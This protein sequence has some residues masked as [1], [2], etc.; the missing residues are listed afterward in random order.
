MINFQC[1]A[2]RSVF[3]SSRLCERNTAEKGG[4]GGCAERI[5]RNDARECKEFYRDAGI[6][7][8]FLEFSPR[9]K[10]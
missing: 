8:L 1:S 6:W 2:L 10:D 4:P 9:K 3:A 7:D 5:D